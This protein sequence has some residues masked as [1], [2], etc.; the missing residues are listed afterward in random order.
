MTANSQTLHFLR[1]HISKFKCV[2]G[3]HD[4]CGPVTAT[5]E[6]MFRL[7]FNSAAEPADAIGRVRLQMDAEAALA[8]LFEA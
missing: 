8:R 1:Q 7:T 5:S 4:S 6:E 2:H 3:C